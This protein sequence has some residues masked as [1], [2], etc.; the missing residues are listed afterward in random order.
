MLGY[1]DPPNEPV[2]NGWS[3]NTGMLVTVSFYSNDTIQYALLFFLYTFSVIF[4]H[5]LLQFFAGCFIKVFSISILVFT[6]FLG[7]F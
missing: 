6:R 2:W 3:S 4:T 1:F 7:P 5:F